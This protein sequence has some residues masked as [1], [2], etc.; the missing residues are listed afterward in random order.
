MLIRIDQPGGGQGRLKNRLE[1]VADTAG[2]LVAQHLGGTLPTVHVVLTGG[3]GCGTLMHRA[4]LA[5]IGGSGRYERTVGRAASAWHARRVFGGTTL[6]RA[7]ILLLINGPRHRGNLRELDRTFVHELAHAVQL[8]G[9]G[10]R[11]QHIQ[12]L[13]Q[14]YGADQRIPADQ[15]AYHRIM[16]IREHQAHNIEALARRLPAA[17]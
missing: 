14:M 13:R 16:D 11:R 5:T 15:Q 3:S 12:Y 2:D 9:P 1:A 8:N 7:G 6:N 17:A 10:A 4:D